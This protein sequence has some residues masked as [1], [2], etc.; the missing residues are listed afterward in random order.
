LATL[1]LLVVIAALATALL[2]Q[3]IREDALRA[4]VKSLQIQNEWE[5][6][7]FRR[8]ERYRQEGRNWPRSQAADRGT[9]GG[10]PPFPTTFTRD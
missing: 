4:Q 8:Y 1:S 6:M 9:R 5:R 3:R 2:V 10:L 7:A